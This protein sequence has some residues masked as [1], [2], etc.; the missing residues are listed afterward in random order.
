MPLVTQ[1][2]KLIGQAYE[3][4]PDTDGWDDLIASLAHLVGGELGVIYIKPSFLRGMGVLAE[5]GADFSTALPTYLSYYEKRSPLLAF[6]RNQPEGSV[7]ALGQF[8]FSP[9]YRET[10]YFTDWVRP[11]GYCDMIGGHLV[12]RP[13]LYSWICIRRPNSFGPYASAELRAAKKIA[14]HLGRAVRLRA[15]I[16]SERAVSRTLG[17][18]LECVRCGVVTVDAGGKVLSANR[19]AEILLR[20]NDGLL[21]QQGKIACECQQENARLQSGLRAAAQPLSSNLDP[22]T[23]FAVI[24][25]GRRPLTVHVIPLTSRAVWSSVASSRA[26]AALFLVDPELESQ[27]GVDAVITGYGLTRAEGNVLREIFRCSGLLKSADNLGITEATART[28]LQ[29]IFSKTDIRNQAELVRLV[30]RSSLS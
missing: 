13:D 20:A 25:N 27:R 23:D 15:K 19:A 30:M 1:I 17:E 22:A 9:A 16:E 18:A 12:R 26:V 11:Q 5:Y 4:V 14:P 24:R 29:R 21:F 10:E 3:M 7:R 28:H 8:A 6:Y 2:D